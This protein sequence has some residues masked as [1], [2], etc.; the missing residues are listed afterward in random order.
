MNLEFNSEGAAAFEQAT[1]QISQN[2]DPQNRFAIVLDGVS[3][4]APSV[5]EAIPGGRAKSP[6]TSP[7]RAPPSWPTS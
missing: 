3:I 5:N 4:S 1:R 2:S 7:R 6:A